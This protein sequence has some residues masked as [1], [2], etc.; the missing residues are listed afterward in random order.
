MHRLPSAGVL[1]LL[2]LTTPALA[3]QPETPI[4]QK[5]LSA[6]DVVATPA[7]DLNLG[8]DEIPALLVAAEERPY[9]LRGLASC[10]HIAAEI[11]RF[12]AL[13][14]EDID[15]PKEGGRRVQPGRMARSVVG[16]LIPFR[17]LIREVSGANAHDRALQEAVLAGVGRRAFLKGVG[18][19]QGCR[20]PARSAT[21][22]VFNQRMAALSTGAE[23]PRLSPD[24][25]EPAPAA[26]PAPPAVREA[27]SGSPGSAVRYVSRPVVQRT[28]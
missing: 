18:E 6:R 17:G 7:T 3:T 14:G 28:Y 15:L 10:Q 25:A 19:K 8:Q 20:Y 26:A 9:T 13:L 22:E 2:L 23:P 21:L 1:A 5:D 27:A 16:S 24:D 4:T 12:D 11:A